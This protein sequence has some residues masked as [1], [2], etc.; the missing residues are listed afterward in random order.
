MNIGRELVLAIA[1][2]IVGTIAVHYLNEIGSSGPAVGLT[3]TGMIF[4][5]TIAIVNFQQPLKHMLKKPGQ[6]KLG[7]SWKSKWSYETDRGT[8]TISDQVRLRQIG[9]FVWGT[10]ESTS[11]DGPAPFEKYHYDVRGTVNPEGI[12]EGQWQ[13]KDEGRNYYGML[14]LRAERGGREMEG[15]WVGVDRYGIRAGRWKWEAGT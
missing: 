15:G 3:V 4:L 7:R 2:S 5:L 14:Q 11:V 6:W 13:N 8:V 10:G 12:V 1:M 9:S